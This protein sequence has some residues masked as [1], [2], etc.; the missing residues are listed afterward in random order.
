MVKYKQIIALCWVVL[1]LWQSPAVAQNRDFLTPQERQFLA[2]N[3]VI[4]VGYDKDYAPIDM[5]NAQ[6]DF[7]GLSA[8]YFAYFSEVLGVDFISASENTWEQTYQKGIEGKFDL[9]S[10]VYI[11]PD[12]EKYF[13]FTDHYFMSQ[14]AII[15]TKAKQ[16]T[17]TS[18]DELSGKKVAVIPGYAVEEFLL[19]RYPNVTLY[20]AANI[21]NGLKEVAFGRVDAFVVAIA[22]ATHYIE[23][24]SITNLAVAGISPY[25]AKL[26]FGVRKDWQIL[27]GILNK[28]LAQMPE[29]KKQAIYK[30]WI[31]Y[32]DAVGK[33][34]RESLKILAALLLVV[35]FAI[36]AM[37]FWNRA[38]SAKVNQRTQELFELNQSLESLVAQRTQALK[39]ANKQLQL[40]K[41]VLQTSNQ[42]LQNMVNC[43]G[44]TGIANRRCLDEMLAHIVSQPAAHLPLSFLLIDVDH[45]KQYND[46]YGHQ[47]GDD[48][49]KQ[50]ATTLAQGVQRQGELAA[51][52]GGEEFAIVLTNCNAQQAF[53]IAERKR[54]QIEQLAIEHQHSSAA[55]VVTI[56]L[57]MV[58]ILEPNTSVEQLINHADEALYLAKQQGRNRVVC[59]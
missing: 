11:E 43:D 26:G 5:E 9:L 54:K 39:E 58:T 44:L 52:Y 10:A 4:T 30:K 18:L 19:K 47:A 2:D 24:F 17:Y 41:S 27:T 20:P 21:A 1:S 55:K 6:G 56:S 31:N 23:Q 42:R 57:G 46:H 50:V 13:S 32:D 29:E 34:D 53:E 25:Q 35:L 16:N 59:A 49:L 3:P 51:R 45:F 7:I 33:R 36:F 22:P 28:V 40:S 12:R 15:T 14:S 48:C 8:D 38:L 37:W